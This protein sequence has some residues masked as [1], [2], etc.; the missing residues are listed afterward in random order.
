MARA[1]RCQGARAGRVLARGAWTC[2]L[3]RGRYGK[4][5][6]GAAF[7]RAEARHRESKRHRQAV[8]QAK[9]NTR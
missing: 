7:I 5:M 2:P 8:K 3:C 1:A 6:T 4:G 9:A